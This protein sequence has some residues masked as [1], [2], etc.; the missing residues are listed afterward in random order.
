M[1]SKNTHFLTLE[2]GKKLIE[3]A[4]KAIILK[5]ENKTPELT[6]YKEFSKKQGV[7]VTLKKNGELRGCIGY[8]LDYY[9]LNEAI[10][11]AA[12]AAAFEDT[13]FPGLTKRELKDIAIEI[14]VLTI[15][16]KIE[17][18]KPEDYLKKIK[19]GRDGLIVKNK[20]TQG[21]L[22]PQVAPEWE[23]NVLELLENTCLKAGLGRNEWKENDV[24][25]Y[26]FQ[27]QIFTEL[28]GDVVEQK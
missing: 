10:I 27:A 4:K 21:L 22:L 12:V 24:E 16:E 19:I 26:S 6:D 7:F 5:F 28:N 25:I 2:Q 1:T 18:K 11:K 23:W 20:F 3:L 13:R 8:P 14:S 9:P 15:P 17:V